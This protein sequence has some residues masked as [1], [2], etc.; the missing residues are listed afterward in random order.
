[1]IPFHYT[2]IYFCDPGVLADVY[3]QN[4]TALTEVHDFLPGPRQDTLH[5]TQVSMVGNVLWNKPYLDDVQ[6]VDDVD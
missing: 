1:M 6:K 2:P 4:H 3:R 5:N